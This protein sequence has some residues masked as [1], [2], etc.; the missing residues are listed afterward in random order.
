MNVSRI[1]LELKVRTNSNL[2]VDQRKRSSLKLTAFGQSGRSQRQ[3][4]ILGPRTKRCLDLPN[5]HFETVHFHTF[6][7]STFNLQKSWTVNFYYFVSST[8]ILLGL[9]HWHSR[10]VHFYPSIQS[11]RL[12]RPMT[13][14]F[15]SADRLLSSWTVHFGLN[16]R[17]VCLETVHF[18]ATVYFKGPPLSPL[19]TVHFRPD[20]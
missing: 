16:D 1:F 5:R 13:V 11:D 8:F 7:P 18:L 3:T 19:S 15:D 6:G 12:L 9:S 10:T 17:P 2:V 14:H 4:R 20:S